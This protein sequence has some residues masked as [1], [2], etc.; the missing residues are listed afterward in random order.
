MTNA[1]VEC[2]LDKS[3]PVSITDFHAQSKARLVIQAIIL[4]QTPSHRNLPNLPISRITIHIINIH[5]VG[6]YA[7]GHLCMCIYTTLGTHNNM[8][9]LEYSY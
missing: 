7:V 4:P 3:D 9:T 8:G 2:N 6:V 5:S 1:M